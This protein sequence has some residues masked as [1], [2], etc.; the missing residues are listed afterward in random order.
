MD[1]REGLADQIVEEEGA[2]IDDLLHASFGEW[3]PRGL[4]IVHDNPRR[5]AVTTSLPD[6]YRFA[7]GE[8]PLFP[9]EGEYLGKASTGGERTIYLNGELLDGYK[10]SKF[11]TLGHETAHILQ[12]D[13]H[14]R[15]RAIM[16]KAGVEQRLKDCF[17]NVAVEQAIKGKFK[18]GT[19]SMIFNRDT[20]YKDNLAYH[21][22]GLEIQARLHQMLMTGYPFWQRLPQNRHEFFFAMKS[23]GCDLPDTVQAVVGHHPDREKLVKA[24]RAL[25]Q[26]WIGNKA[27]FK[28]CFVEDIDWLVSQLTDKGRENFWHEA[29]P[30][31]YA[32]LIEMYGD[33]PGRERFGLGTNETHLLRTEHDKDVTLIYALKWRTAYHDRLGKYAFALL[34]HDKKERL[35]KAFENQYITPVIQQDGHATWVLVS[36]SVSMGEL[37]FCIDAARPT[38]PLP[39]LLKHTRSLDRS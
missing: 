3:P 16:G 22:Q 28:Y 19:L 33:K 27:P 25:P 36:G 6:F 13:H 31:L 12:G 39:S 29:M 15:I 10:Y 34:D 35:I 5:V 38:S 32:D 7:Y 14:W 24:F 26:I 2:S 21:K 17:S 4:D 23:V 30:R 20:R 1:K 18:R 9:D 37:K 11:S 8:P